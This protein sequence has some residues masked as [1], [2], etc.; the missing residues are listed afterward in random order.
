[1][2]GSAILAFALH[3]GRL[4]GEGAFSLSQLDETFQAEHWGVDEEAAA[5]AQALRGEAMMLDAW[6]RSLG[7]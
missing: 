1:L 7:A 4:D 5:R 2:L 3:R 6:F